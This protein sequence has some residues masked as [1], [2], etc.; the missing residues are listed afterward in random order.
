MVDEFFGG[1][2]ESV[3]DELGGAV[4]LGEGGGCAAVGGPFRF[5]G[6]GR[7]RVGVDVGFD[8]GVDVGFDVG[9]EAQA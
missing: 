1:E 5:E 7:D 9:L 6:V 4:D 2:V 8:V 3:V